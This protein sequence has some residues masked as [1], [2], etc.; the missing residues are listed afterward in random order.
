MASTLV[1]QFSERTMRTSTPPQA[2]EILV[3][4]QPVLGECAQRCAGGGVEKDLVVEPREQA[5]DILQDGRA[6][7][8]RAAPFGA[9]GATAL[10]FAARGAAGPVQCGAQGA[11]STGGEK[12]AS[13]HVDR[14]GRGARQPSG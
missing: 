2:P 10:I 12:V 3:L 7:A 9:A 14:P 6:A 13:V 4:P 11:T 5:A 8:D 1:R